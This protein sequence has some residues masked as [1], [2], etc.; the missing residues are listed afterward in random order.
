MEERNELCSR[1]VDAAQVGT[2]SEVTTV[3]GQRQVV[4][5]V[6]SVVLLGDNVLDVMS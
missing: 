2:L 1:R 6:G 5:V 3:A 4:I